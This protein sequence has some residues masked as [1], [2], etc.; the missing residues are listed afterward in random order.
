MPAEPND[1]AARGF[2]PALGALRDAERIIVRLR[3]LAMASWLPILL[4]IEAPVPAVWV[5]GAYAVTLL[6][7]ATTHAL[8][9]QGRAIRATALA[10]TILDPA[11]TALICSVTG[12]LESDLYPFF[13]LTTLA[14]SI[15][16]G[17]RE[18][19]ATVV[20]NSGLSSLLFLAAPGSTATVGDLALRIFYLF[21]VALEGGLL[22]R[23]ARS[24]SLRRQEVLRRLITVEEEER[25]RLAGEIHDRLGRRFFSFYQALDRRR[26]DLAPTDAPTASLL[27]N[28]SDEA[29]GC[30]DEIRNL[31]NALRP[32]VLDDF[33][34]VEALREHVAAI[35][36]LEVTLH[37]DSPSPTRPEAGVVLYRVLEE[38]IA[39]VRRH[40]SARRV[41]IDLVGGNGT[42]ELRVR[43]DGRGF[44]P[45]A[46]PRGHFG[47]LYMR[48]RVEG[49]GGSLRIG[50][51][52]GSGT[53][54]RATVPA[55]SGDR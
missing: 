25:R 34:F 32:V 6:Y 9:R 55:G 37:I 27:A 39:N 47:L 24:H 8:N 35:G 21:F 48:E 10:T 17:M 41:E 50:S 44:D 36:D 29:R 16:F 38:A 26:A 40:A 53:E 42:L 28:L 20:L 33:G 15:R 43:D 1:G 23:A 52:P 49:C 12:G 5:W 22:S 13:Y 18:T 31:S 2:G 7:V 54:V 14:T 46:L 30:A 11:V 19:L 3:W 45:D 51:R 4:R